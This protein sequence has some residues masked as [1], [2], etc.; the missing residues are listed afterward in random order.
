MNYTE[1]NL[2]DHIEINLHKVGF[3]SLLY[4]EY[5]RVNCVVPS[6]L[7]QFI[8]ETQN[9]VYERLVEQYGSDTDTKLILR[10]NNEVSS[11]GVIDV[12][13][14][15]IKDRG[16]HFSL[17]YFEPKSG[18]NPEHQELYLKNRV[19]IIRQ[20]HYSSKNHNSL[21]MV[22]FI[23]GL[24]IITMELKNQLTGQTILD[25]EKQYRYDRDPNEPLFQFKRV[26]VH[27]CCDND[28]VSMTTRLMG[29]KTKFL[30]YNKGI[31]NPINPSGLKTS[32][33]WEEILTKESLLDILENF[34]HVSVETDK[35]F[36]P[37]IGKVVEKKKELLVFPRYHQLDVIRKLRID[38]KTNGVGHNYLIQHTTGS[39]KS[40]SIGWLSHLLTSLYR[41]KED[42][43]RMFD[44][45]IV[46]T[47]RKVLDKQLQTT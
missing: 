25:S 34:V 4:T 43:N 22:L 7:I 45:I 44:S 24:P 29:G 32:Y 17:V 19:T 5:D 9:E 21:D 39:G 41:T 33:L 23:N 31:E 14:K 13:R 12:I 6:D 36:D 20:V 26:L 46:I 10:L 40:Y 1:K 38:V 27:F 37:K 30:P 47:D 2:E 15:G 35:D 28:R 18:L 42:N 3:K 11:R 8:K 16:C